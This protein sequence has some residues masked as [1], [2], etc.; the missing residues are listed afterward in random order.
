MDESDGEGSLLA[1]PADSVW[2][3][4]GSDEVGVGV[5]VGVGPVLGGGVGL[6][7]FDGVGLGVGF[8]V[9]VLGDGLG[10]GFADFVWDGLG[11]GVA[12]AFGL[13]LV[14]GPRLGIVPLGRGDGLP[15]RYG[16]GST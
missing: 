16:D 11:D 7:V 10:V 13:R 15:V 2:V 5:G 14:V 6:G 4:L 9:L 1:R 8:G 3:G 12:T